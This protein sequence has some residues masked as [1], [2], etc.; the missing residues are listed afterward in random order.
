MV[1]IAPVCASPIYRH[2]YHA[3]QDATTTDSRVAI[4]VP[5]YEELQS[6]YLCRHYYK[7]HKTAVALYSTSTIGS[8]PRNVRY[9]TYC[10]LA[11]GCDCYF[12]RC[13]TTTLYYYFINRST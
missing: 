6:C 10:L 5:L 2:Y 13:A 1:I 4:H 7:E 12:L 3:I 9:D 11:C 8:S